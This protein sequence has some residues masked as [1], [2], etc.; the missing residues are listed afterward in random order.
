MDETQWCLTS[1]HEIIIAPCDAETFTANFS[2]DPKQSLT[3]IAMI[4]A[5][6]EKM[7]L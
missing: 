6:G 7:P 5:A 4:N 3:V 1:S 2:C